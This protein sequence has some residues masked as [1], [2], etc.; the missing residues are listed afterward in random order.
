MCVCACVR[1]SVRACVCECVCAR[2]T[3]EVH[4]R[5]QNASGTISKNR[6]NERDDGAPEGL[7][8]GHQ[9]KQQGQSLR[10]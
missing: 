10:L 3:R 7:E 4:A 6:V 8:D 2:A 5:D 1:V 9:H